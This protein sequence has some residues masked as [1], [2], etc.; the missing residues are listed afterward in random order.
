LAGVYAAL[1][2]YHLNRDEIEADILADAEMTVASPAT[3]VMTHRQQVRQALMAVGLS[4]P[5]PDTPPDA[6]PISAERR[7]ELARLFAGER[8]LSELIIDDREG[9]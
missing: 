6:T 3:E 9:R 8:P 7:A 4:L 2:Y 5:T 1:A